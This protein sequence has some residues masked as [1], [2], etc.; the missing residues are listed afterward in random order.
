MDDPLRDG[1]PITDDPDDDFL[2]ALADPVGA[3]ALV[4]GDPHLTTVRREG[5]SVLTPRAALDD[6]GETHCGE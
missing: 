4:S 2:V 3:D 1:T 6:I 5:V